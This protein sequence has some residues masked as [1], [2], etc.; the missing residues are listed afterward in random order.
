MKLYV[1]NAQKW[2]DFFERVS[3]GQTQ[4]SQT[5]RG[6]RPHVITVDQSKQPPVKAVLPADQT[7]AQAK[8]E[9]ERDG[10]NPKD[11]AKAF[12]SSTERGRKREATNAK[13]G[14]GK[15]KK[16]STKTTAKRY[17]KGFNDI[18]KID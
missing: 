8:A 13:K 12:Q 5:G 15:R 9:L 1:P 2:M 16:T 18:F 17:H 10:I 6:R 3:T 14:N 4:L 7:A 11:V